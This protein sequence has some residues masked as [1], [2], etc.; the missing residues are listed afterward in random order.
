[1]NGNELLLQ[2]TNII[3]RKTLGNRVFLAVGPNL[4]NKLPVSIRGEEN[5]KR[6]KSLLKTYLFREAYSC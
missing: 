3:T 4:W 6:F 2:P 5:L 1:M